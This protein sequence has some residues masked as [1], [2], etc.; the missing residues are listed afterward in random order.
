[1]EFSKSYLQDD[2]LLMNAQGWLV[3]RAIRPEGKPP[4]GFLQ[5]MNHPTMGSIAVLQYL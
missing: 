5:E 2:R 3:P 4:E 1:M